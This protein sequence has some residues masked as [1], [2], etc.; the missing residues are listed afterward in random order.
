MR[1][2]Q[3]GTADKP[4]G[5]PERG[6]QN[7]LED[8]H[9]LARYDRHRRLRVMSMLPVDQVMDILATKPPGGKGCAHEWLQCDPLNGKYDVL[10]FQVVCPGGL[11]PYEV[12][13]EPHL[14][15]TVFAEDVAPYEGQNL[16]IQLDRFI[17]AVK[18]VIGRFEEEF[19]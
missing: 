18:Y 2:I 4:V 17:G 9:N 12:C 7:T 6:L 8:I 5:H 1:T 13:V 14:A 10:R 3:P 15:F 11:F 16:G 19:A